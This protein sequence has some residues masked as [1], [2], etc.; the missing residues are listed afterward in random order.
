ML[1]DKRHARMP[2]A[3]QMDD[4]SESGD[5]AMMARRMR[6]QRAEERMDEDEDF[7]EGELLDMEDQKGDIKEWLKEPKTIQFIRNAF[8][9]FLRN[10][11]ENEDKD[12]DVYEERIN[13]MCH[14]N[15]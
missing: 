11:R 13:E 4:E 2:M 9:K 3:M 1:A 10:Y 8:N 12:A 7:Q 6:Q 15:R 14:N 5:E